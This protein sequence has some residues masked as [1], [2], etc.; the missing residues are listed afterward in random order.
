[1]EIRDIELKTGSAVGVAIP[2]P[3]SSLVL[4][5]AKRG[6]VMCGYLDL[7]AAEKMKDAAAVVTGVKTV[8]ELLEG[9]VKK[10]TP[11]AARR[12]IRVGMTGLQALE[13]LA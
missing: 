11:A 9:M 10:V 13:K 4:A 8:D 6:F 3:N 2:M 5:V 7:A 1:M 12:G